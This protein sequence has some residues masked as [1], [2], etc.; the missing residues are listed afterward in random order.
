MD[1]IITAVLNMKKLQ[2]LKINCNYTGNSEYTL[3][4]K[5]SHQTMLKAALPALQFT[6]ALKFK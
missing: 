5:I 2:T 6:S 1:A 3:D 4:K